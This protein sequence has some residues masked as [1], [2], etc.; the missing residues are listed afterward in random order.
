[1]TM[2]MTMTMMMH[3]LLQLQKDRRRRRG[4]AESWVSVITGVGKHSQVKPHPLFFVALPHTTNPTQ[5]GAAQ[6]GR[7]QIRPAVV[8]HLKDNGYHYHEVDGEVLVRVT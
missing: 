6:G 8:R 3:R 2:T 7:A 4:D 5:R 1:M